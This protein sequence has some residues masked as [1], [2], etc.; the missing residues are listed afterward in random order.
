[1]PEDA[2]LFLRRPWDLYPL[3]PDA[4]TPMKLRVG[5]EDIGHTHKIQRRRIEGNPSRTIHR[6][7]YFPTDEQLAAMK[8]FYPND[9]PE[10]PPWRKIETALVVGG[11][12]PAI[13][14]DISAN[15]LLTI[16]MSLT[17]KTQA[18]NEHMIDL[19]QAAAL[20][21]R[22]KRTLER[23]QKNPRKH[24]PLPVI[25]GG[26]GK[27][28]EWKYSELKP[29]LEREFDRLLPDKPPHVGH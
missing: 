28:S 15:V 20:V 4:I 14:G 17:E 7:L 21:N 1:M 13:M 2:G 16:L 18:K 12:D 19:D 27:K 11:N 23:Y 22:S 6:R 10:R 9:D 25:Q 8:G 29:W 26:A 5:Q 3:H 24:M